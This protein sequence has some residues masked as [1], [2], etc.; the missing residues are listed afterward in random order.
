MNSLGTRPRTGLLGAML[1]YLHFGTMSPVPS[2]ALT[3]STDA[4]WAPHPLPSG[5]RDF[6]TRPYVFGLSRECAKQRRKN[7]LRRLG[8]GGQRR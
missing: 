4:N 1:A 7:K 3:A 5:P 6:G 8:I 2:Y